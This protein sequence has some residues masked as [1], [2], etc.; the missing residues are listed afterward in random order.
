MH[1]ENNN[2]FYFIFFF[3]IVYF[4]YD[5]YSIWFNKIKDYYP[6]LIHHCASIYFLQCLFNYE[7]AIK[8]KM[9]LGYI[10]LE[11]TNLPSYYIYYFIKTNKTK[12]EE[13]YKKLLNMKKIQIGLYIVLR[14][15]IFAYL[16]KIMYNNVCHQPVLSSCIIGLYF[17]GIYWLYKLSQGYLKTK[18]NYTKVIKNK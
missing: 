11:I 3:S 18:S 17:M 12:N 5:S 14:I 8:N 13:Y 9:I 16:M 7:G 1:V 10:I 15:F 4:I 6:F 2:L